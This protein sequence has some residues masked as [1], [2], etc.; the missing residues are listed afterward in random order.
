MLIQNI[1]G[2][3]PAGSYTSAG[4]SVSAPPA[5]EHAA[6][7]QS[8]GAASAAATAAADKSAATSKEQ[9]QQAIDSINSSM[10]KIN[11][12]LEFSVDQDSH[13]VVVKVVESKTGDVIKQFP[14]EETLS[15]AK[16]IDRFQQGVLLQQKA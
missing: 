10:K 14:S 3:V 6:G 5:S 1:G 9:L 15:I 8:Q 12:D 11:A 13:R 4:V 16:A 2:T 7:T